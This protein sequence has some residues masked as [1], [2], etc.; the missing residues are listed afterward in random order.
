MAAGRNFRGIR[1][2]GG[3]PEKIKFA[4]PTTIEACGVLAKLGAQH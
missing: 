2:L 4:D 1:Y 3:A